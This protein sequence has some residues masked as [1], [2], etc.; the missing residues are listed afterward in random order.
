MEPYLVPCGTFI[1]TLAERHDPDKY[2]QAVFGPWSPEAFVCLAKPTD[3]GAS[4]V[5]SSFRLRDTL[6][7]EAIEFALPTQH[8]FGETEL[9]AVVAGLIDLQP[10]AESGKLCNDGSDNLFYA[11][12]GVIDVYAATDQRWWVHSWPRG[13]NKWPAGSQVFSLAVA[14]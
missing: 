11:D 12:P 5:V 4:F 14:V 10:N 2:Y 9:S 7:D 13:K 3:A 1:I 6:D 8:L